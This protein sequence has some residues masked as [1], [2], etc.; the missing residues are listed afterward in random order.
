MIETGDVLGKFA[1]G[2]VG[3]GEGDHLGFDDR[4][5]VREAILESGCGRI[6]VGHGDLLMAHSCERAQVSGKQRYSRGFGRCN[7]AISRKSAILR[8]PV[9]RSPMIGCTRHRGLP[10]G[11]SLSSFG[12][13]SPS[14]CPAPNPVSMTIRYLLFTVLLLIA[15]GAR[16]E[17]PAEIAGFRVEAGHLPCQGAREFMRSRLRSLDRRRRQGRPRCGG[18]RQPFPAWRKGYPTP[19]LL[20]LAGRRG[21]AS[22][23][24]RTLAAQPQGDC[25]GRAHDRDRMRRRIPDR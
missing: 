9:H 20:P 4:F 13:A 17:T 11:P 5:Q 24:D 23:S 22:L 21:G 14:S 3:K 8:S 16:A 1:P 25:P 6:L 10:R 2:A 18:P 12:R 7:R 15:G 19:D